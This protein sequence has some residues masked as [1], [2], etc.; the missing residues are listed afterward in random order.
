MLLL[1][2]TRLVV[3][4]GNHGCPSLGYPGSQSARH[5]PS[6]LRSNLPG[7]KPSSH[8]CHLPGISGS[9]EGT[10][11]A[12]SP[13]AGRRGVSGMSHAR[14]TPSKYHACGFLWETES[15]KGPFCSD[16]LLLTEPFGG[17]WQDLDAV[18]SYLPRTSPNSSD[19]L[20]VVTTP[21]RQCTHRSGPARVS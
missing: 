13:G 3:G 17:L 1:L 21:H 11:V 6:D 18:L 8:A 16:L 9:R 2:F 10:L 20:G 15:W 4:L 14:M 5:H 7:P 19:G 12:G